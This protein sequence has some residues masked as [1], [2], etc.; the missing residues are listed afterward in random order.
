MNHDRKPKRRLQSARVKLMIIA[1]GGMPFLFEGCDPTLR[2]TLESGIIDS[3]TAA[4]A[5]F[6]QAFVELATAQLAAGLTT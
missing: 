6:L 4:F 2:S 1:S 5:S 3:V